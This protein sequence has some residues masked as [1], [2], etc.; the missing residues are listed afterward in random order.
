MKHV[1]AKFSFLL[2]ITSCV[3]RGRDFSSDVSWLKENMTKKADVQMV[4]GQPFS[5]GNSSGTPTWTYGLYKHSLFG[6]SNTKELKLFF[7]DDHTIK[8]FSF[9]SSFPEDVQ[10]SGLNYPQGKK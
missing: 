4:L 2:L 7:N 1:V 10:K 9:N 3:T 5:V 6:Q 8:S